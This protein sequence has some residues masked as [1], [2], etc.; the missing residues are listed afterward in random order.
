MQHIFIYNILLKLFKRTSC[1]VGGPR[2]SVC[3]CE[4][5]SGINSDGKMVTALLETSMFKVSSL[6][7]G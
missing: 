1:G 3:V 7:I 4:I 6:L 5:V 2:S